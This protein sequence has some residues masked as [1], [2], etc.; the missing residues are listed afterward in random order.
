M[1]K[2]VPG[3]DSSLLLWPKVASYPEPQT[4]QEARYCPAAA[5]VWPQDKPLSSLVN[6]LI[7]QY[8]NLKLVIFHI[9]HATI[10]ADWIL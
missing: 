2:Q 1:P 4:E 6:L 10:D 5:P 3:G 7:C 8:F 9:Q